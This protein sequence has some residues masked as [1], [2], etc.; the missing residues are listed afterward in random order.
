MSDNPVRTIVD[1]VEGALPFQRYFV[2]RRCEPQVRGFFFEGAS[3]ARPAGELLAALAGPQLEAILICP[4]NPYLSID[5]ILTVPGMREALENAAAPVVAV[6]PIIRGAAVKGPTTKIMTDLG[7]ERTSAAIAG[8][9]RGLIGGLMIDESDAAD[10]S[11]LDIAVETAPTLM[12]DLEDRETLARRVLAF[13][14]SLASM[15]ADPRRVR[16]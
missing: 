12:R 4:S 11:T 16:A 10:G 5:P 6:S 15:R 2:E 7:V 3:A 14:R 1:T 8:H 13:A 9:Y